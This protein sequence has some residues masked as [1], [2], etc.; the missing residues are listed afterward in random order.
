[1]LPGSTPVWESADVSILEA[2]SY[3]GDLVVAIWDTRRRCL[4]RNIAQS[5]TGKDRLL[6]V[7]NLPAQKDAK[8]LYSRAYSYK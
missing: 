5:R 8:Y 2:L 7:L 1:V 4:S 6:R 3:G